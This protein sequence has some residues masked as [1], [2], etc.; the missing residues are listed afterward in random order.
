MLGADQ[1]PFA[2]DRAALSGRKSQYRFECR[3]FVSSGTL[4]PRAAGIDTFMLLDV[5][6]ALVRFLLL[7]REEQ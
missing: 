7:F 4:V 1:S 2:P 6:S 5:R 3:R